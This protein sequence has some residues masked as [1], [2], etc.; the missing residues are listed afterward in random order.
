MSELRNKISTVPG[1]MIKRATGIPPH[2]QTAV[3]MYKLINITTDTLEEVRNLT[4]NMRTV[5][6]D[7]IDAKSLENGQVSVSKVK[8]YS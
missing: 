6:S 2:I 3:T 7:A 1:N 4:L 8:K 5:I